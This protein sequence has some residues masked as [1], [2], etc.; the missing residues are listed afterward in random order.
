MKKYLIRS[1]KYLI[2]CLVFFFII[3]GL[4]FLWQY[5]KNPDMTCSCMFKEGSMPK[6]VIFFLLVAGTYPALG[7]VKRKFHLNGDYPKYAEIIEDAF[8]EA[9][10]KLDKKD[11]EKVI[12]RHAKAVTRLTR[13][14]ED[15]ITFDLTQDP[16]VVDG[17][18]KDVD[19]I[20]RNVSYRIRREEEDNSSQDA[21]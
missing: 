19:R 18:R 21:Q 4:L 15:A 14:Y 9:G 16:I 11:D 5:A 6:L 2:Y 7:F 13:M 1:I 3:V 8:R 10:Y 12:F 17:I 20:L